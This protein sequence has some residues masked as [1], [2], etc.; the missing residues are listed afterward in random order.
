MSRRPRFLPRWALW[1][2]LCAWLLAAQQQAWLHPLAHLHGLHGLHGP[3]PNLARDAASAHDE[4]G[5]DCALCLACAALA[6]PA[7]AAGTASP[8]L[9]Q[10]EAG[11][12]ILTE[13]GL[14]ARAP[15]AAHNRGPPGRA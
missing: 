1:L 14:A 10:A 4:A 2:A 9:P 13:P 3:S 8:A 5:L 7:T 12:A 11:V 15:V 6:H